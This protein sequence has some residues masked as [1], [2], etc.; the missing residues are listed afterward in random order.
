MADILGIGISALQSAQAGLLTTQNNIANANTPGYHRQII[1]QVQLPSQLTGSGYV[2]SGVV[3]DGVARVYSQ[4]LDKQL[5]SVGTQNSYLQTYNQQVTQIDNFLADPNAGLSPAL[6]SFF[7]AVQDVA[8][9]PSSVP[10]RQALLS[11]ANALVGRFTSMQSRFND[12]RDGINQQVQSTV[13]TINSYS[14]QIASLNDQIALATGVADSG[15]VPNDLLDQRDQLIGQLNQ[16]VKVSTVS[17]SNGELNVFIGQG[18]PLVVGNHATQLSTMQSQEDPDNLVVGIITSG[19]STPR[20]ISSSLLSGGSLGGLLDFRSQSLDPAQ[21]ALG[22]VAAGLVQTFNAQHALGVDL[23]GTLGNN[24]FN[25]FT[26][27]AAPVVQANGLNTSTASI[28]AVYANTADLTT[29]NYRISFDGT[30]YSLTDLSTNKVTTGISPAS[31]ATA[32]PGLTLTVSTTPNAGD[33]FLVLP[34]RY[35]SRDINVNVTNVSEIAA[36]LPVTTGTGTANTGTGVISAG[37][38]TST[39]TLPTSAVTMTYNSTTQKFDLTSTDPSWNGISVPTSGTYTSGATISVNG[40]SFAVTGAPA[41]GDVFT[42]NPN[43]G[44]SFTGDADNRNAMK[45]GALISK[46]TLV[47]NSSG[48]PTASYQDAYSQL[49]SFIGNQTSEMQVKSTAQ[50][51]LLD[52]ATQAQQSF[53]GVNLDEEAANLVRYQ[54]AYQA[55]AKSIQTAQT[56]FQ[57]LLSLGG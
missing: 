34:T 3:V 43:Y 33:S 37:D 32:V 9:N 55:A 5:L 8:S 51:T 40:V 27:T 39:S 29:S 25:T 14:K 15:Q 44:A 22:R 48:T 42:L 2:G 20:E 1:T 49:V 41:N 23:N 31:L 21:N 56:V 12:I 38:V 50:Q 6:Q 24:F 28:S 47:N 46:Q 35:A 10:S 57:T 19:S 45:L 7:S 26:G 17:G 30:N 52:Q 13:N 54:Y 53:S 16:L 4:F 18:Q 36:A 11:N